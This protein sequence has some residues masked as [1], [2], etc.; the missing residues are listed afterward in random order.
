VSD[1]QAWS[2][3]DRDLMPSVFSQLVDRGVLFTRAYV[4]SS[5]CCPSRSEILTGLYE[6]NTGVDGN[7]IQLTR[8]T[9]VEALHDLGYRTALA[10]KYLNSVRCDPRPEFDR[11]MCS[12]HKPSDYSLRDPYLNVNGSWRRFR[13][14]TVQ[15][16]ADFISGFIQQTPPGQPFFAMYTPTSPH[17]PANDDRYASLP[18]SPLRGP[19]YDQ[20][21]RSESE[22]LHMRRPPISSAVAQKIDS[23]HA[24]MTRAVRA[25]DDSI[26]TILSYLG[27]RDQDTLVICTEST[28]GEASRFRTRKRYAYRSSFATPRPRR[29][30]RP[31][32]TR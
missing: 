9:I 8:P 2:T 23:D 11:W 31:S 4:D 17:L 7:R 10:G 1:D 28:A 25:L 30:G 5:L 26:A 22:P 19:A 13:G 18:V 3:F 24:A 27:D 12:G 6:H 21:T 14:Y 20:E 15:I 16:Q 32:P 29:A